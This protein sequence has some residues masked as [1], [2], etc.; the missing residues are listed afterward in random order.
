M[1]LCVWWHVSQVTG[2]VSHTWQVVAPLCCLR[3]T[4]AAI[5]QLAMQA[6]SCAALTGMATLVWYGAGPHGG[7]QAAAIEHD[8]KADVSGLA[9]VLSICMVMYNAQM[10]SVS[11]EQDMKHRGSYLRTLVLTQASVVILY[12]GFGVVIYFFFGAATGRVCT[13]P[14][15]PSPTAC[16]HWRDATIFQNIPPGVFFTT[17][18]LA[19]SLNLTFMYP[20]TMLPAS[21]AIEDALGVCT[22]VGSVM[23]RL[24]IV[25]AMTTLGMLL[26]SFEFLQSLTGA[27]TTC[28]LLSMPSYAFWTLR[29]NDMGPVHVR[30]CW[31]VLV[32]GVL[33]SIFSTVQTVY[34][35]AV[36]SA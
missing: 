8:T 16:Q 9:T 29:K 26:P 30:W 23:L 19:V 21:K 27:M 3:T 35:R 12:L 18:K 6:G 11:I 20:V 7:F 15:S 33:C 2:F 4:D 10:E 32:F 14:G 22:R 25:A 34:N 36:G 5:F 13:D 28:T 1:V 24:T 17:V 31:F